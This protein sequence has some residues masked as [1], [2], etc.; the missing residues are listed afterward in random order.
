MRLKTINAK[1]FF[2]YS[3]LIAA[4]V[5]C[6]LLAFSYYMTPILRSE[7]SQSMHQISS[8]IVDT[9][10]L[11]L[12]AIYSTALKVISSN[13]VRDALFKKSNDPSE[14]NRDRNLLANSILS[15]NGPIPNFHKVNLYRNDG[16]VFEYGDQYFSRYGDRAQLL[17]ESWVQETFKQ[18]GRKYISPPHTD[19]GSESS[20]PIISVS[21]SFAEVYGMKNNNIV[22]VQQK[23]SVF[24]NIIQKAVLSSRSDKKSTKSVYVLDRQGNVI[25]PYGNDAATTAIIEGFRDVAL[26]STSPTGEITV[27]N[28]LNHKKSMGV[29]VQSGVSGWLVLLLEP[30]S[31]LT[32]PIRTFN[33]NI[34]AF[35]IVALILTLIVT[36]FVSRSLSTPIKRI[37]KLLRTL[38]LDSLVP[39]KNMIVR[40]QF[41][42]LE[43]LNRTII[44][45][46]DRLKES[47]E[48]A[49][50]ARSHE[51]QS[52]LLA[53]QSQ[54]N[55]H[56]LYN[57]LSVIGIMSEEGRNEDAVRFC[58][59]LSHILRY[60]SS[61]NFSAVPL[62]EE[63]RHAEEY[64][65]LMKERYG[66]RLECEIHIPEAMERYAIPKLVVQP[67]VENCLKYAIDV[68]PPWTIR[69]TGRL[70][71][72]GWMLT[73]SDNGGGFDPA[74]LEE[75]KRKFGEIDDLTSIPS[76][77]LNG[78][79][80]ANIYTRLKLYYEDRMI[81]DMKN[82]PAGGA[83]VTIGGLRNRM[84][85]G[86]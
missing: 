65:S 36:Y 22:E 61:T 7:S 5:L 77:G 41:D 43:E 42:E 85:V 4:I 75:L 9:L 69:I 45:M 68:R 38:E 63:I 55:P 60:T 24:D 37:S 35:G 25:Y 31:S 70:L 30:E 67:L 71:T 52:R 23:Y 47:L 40:S 56:F 51:L 80:L 12:N 15:I 14:E 83:S 33:R 62:S 53:L 84:G 20:E 13:P 74:A 28:P 11:E 2:R 27:D 48:E 21:M 26:K 10:D 81:F 86:A 34:I 17:Q 72:D 78:M 32:E 8:N 46:R 49:V 19:A 3:L 54:M 50:S 64:V 82:N 58:R 1:I 44:E 57:S 18:N 66:D 39:P 59:G 6:F 79:G 29:Y 76:I 16:F 73:V